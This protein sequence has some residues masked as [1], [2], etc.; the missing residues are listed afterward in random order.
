MSI[1]PESKLSLRTILSAALPPKAASMS[2]TKV[3][4]SMV[5]RKDG[6]SNVLLAR[7]FK[8]ASRAASPVYLTAV[9]V[10]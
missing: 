5:I 10:I 7:Q 9:V 1:E 4:D 8:T 2:P 3:C 6:N